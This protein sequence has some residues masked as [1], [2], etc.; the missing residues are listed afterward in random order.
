MLACRAGN[1]TFVDYLLAKYGD[2]ILADVQNAETGETALIT[3]ARQGHV[4]IVK[5]LV[6]WA[7]KSDK[8]WRRGR[9]G[10]F[11][12]FRNTLG[13]KRSTTGGIY[14]RLTRIA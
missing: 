4:R 9:D 14:P 7:T 6:A 8:K 1:D 12:C 5:K 11:G 10:I 13:P 2:D 3:A